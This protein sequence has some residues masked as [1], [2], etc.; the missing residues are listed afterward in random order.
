MDVKAF[1]AVSV[2][3]FVFSC[4]SAQKD[5]VSL[6]ADCIGYGMYGC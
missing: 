2:I 1:F 5:K 3:C 6:P 4:N